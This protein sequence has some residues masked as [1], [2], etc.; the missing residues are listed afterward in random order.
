M[1]S[2]TPNCYE[3]IAE[4]RRRIG[5][6]ADVPLYF[7]FP[8]S[9]IKNVCVRLP[10]NTESLLKVSG[11]GKVKVKKYGDEVLKIVRQ[12]REDKNI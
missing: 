10:V 4:M 11:F 5:D 6:E 3:R 2:G 1:N 7:I 8:N 9:T 12:Y